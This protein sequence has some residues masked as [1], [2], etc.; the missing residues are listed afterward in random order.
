MGRF[1]VRRLMK[2]AGVASRQPTLMP[3]KSPG[4]SD[5]TSRICWLVNLP[6][7]SPIRCGVAILLTCGPLA[8]FDDGAGPSYPASRGLVNV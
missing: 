3:T 2:D 8:L 4:L 1:K 6:F 5:R 7:R